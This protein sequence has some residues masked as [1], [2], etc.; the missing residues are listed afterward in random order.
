M[1]L[2]QDVRDLG[3]WDVELDQSSDFLVDG[4]SLEGVQDPLLDPVDLLDVPLRSIL[5]VLDLFSHDRDMIALCLQLLVTPL[6]FLVYDLLQLNA[7]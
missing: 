2:L 1:Q 7:D 6:E 3:L 4:G 5:G